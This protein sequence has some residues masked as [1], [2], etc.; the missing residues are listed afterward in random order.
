MDR[1]VKFSEFIGILF[2]F[3]IALVTLGYTYGT[4]TAEMRTE[5]TTQGVKISEM[6]KQ[7][8]EDKQEQNKKWD[9]IFNKLIDIQLLLENKQDRKR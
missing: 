1:P 8:R 6:E 2:P 5:L 3:I 4:K 9:A 7:A